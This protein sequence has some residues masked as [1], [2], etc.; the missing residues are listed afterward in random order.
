M[1][2][3]TIVDGRDKVRLCPWRGT[4][5]TASLIPVTAGRPL[6]NQ[7]LTRAVDALRANGIT[8]VITAA[9]SPTD[10]APFLDAGFR[11]NHELHLL[12]IAPM[13]ADVAALD[14]RRLRAARRADWPAVIDID[15]SAF[16]WFW[17]FDHRAIRDAL[18]ATPSRRFQVVRG[19]PV[20][21]YHITGRS[22][23]DGFLQRL[24]VSDG[25][26]G[27]GIGKLLLADSLDWLRRRNV[28]RCWVNTQLDN[29]RAYGLYRS[30]GFEPA[31]YRLAVLEADLDERGPMRR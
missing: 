27:S 2:V 16:D 13:D 24:A 9:M 12:S 14:S 23:S 7:A 11:V 31:S 28:Q 25:A 19:Q 20:T 17:R 18:Q 21:G 6:R 5:D 30:V 3:T 8:R 4:T 22:H 10:A 15:A 26:Q 29:E 1:Q